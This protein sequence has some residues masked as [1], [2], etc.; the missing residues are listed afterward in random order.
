MS[1]YSREGH[2]SPLRFLFGREGG[3]DLMPDDLKERLKGFAPPPVEA[4]VR[5]VETLP[6]VHDQPFDRWNPRTKLTEKG[7][8][9]VPGILDGADDMYAIHSLRLV[10][11]S[12]MLRSCREPRP[13]STSTFRAG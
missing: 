6:E 2:V 4:N 7:T 11:V 12:L 3:G 8:E 5:S 9:A 10:S 13:D 1:R